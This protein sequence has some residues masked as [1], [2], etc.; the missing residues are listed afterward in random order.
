MISTNKR[1]IDKKTRRKKRVEKRNNAL[2]IKL[3]KDKNKI[4]F[5]VEPFNKDI[6]SEEFVDE[7]TKCLQE[8]RL[9]NRDLFNLGEEQF[10][11]LMKKH[12]FDYALAAVLSQFEDAN[13]NLFQQH[14]NC[15]IG[16]LVFKRLRDKNLLFN[17]IPYSNVDIIP[18]GN[19]FIIIF[20]S[21][22]RH[23][24]KFGYVFYSSLKPTVT[25]E[26]ESYIVAFSRH[27]V[28][29]ICERTVFDW[30]SY[31]GSGD[32]FAYL[33]R[34]IKFDVITN[35][36]N[37]FGKKLITFYELCMPGFSNMTYVEEVLKHSNNDKEYCY[38]VGYCPIGLNDNFA[39]AITL[40][41]P[42]MKGTPEDY[43]IKNKN[44]TYENERKI[45][46]DIQDIISKK[47]WVEKR[48]FGAIKWFQE[49]GIE[50]VMEVKE[51]L[52]HDLTLTSI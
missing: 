35:I 6:I 19:E 9:N 16:D 14:F 11:K 47:V 29:R 44:L 45:R 4:S 41:T 8:M 1:K 20:R 37:K 24:S 51:K 17:Y 10:F 27:A 43:L 48:N 39:C 31:S 49:N 32:A 25:I 33:E 28:Q 34:C 23:R 3:E 2:E 15:K 22:L 26:N 21:L 50:Q 46:N 42:G 36:E 52:F 12:G 38:R 30:Q 5:R 18:R 7:V 40:L 13:I